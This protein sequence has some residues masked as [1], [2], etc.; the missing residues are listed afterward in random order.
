MLQLMEGNRTEGM[1]KQNRIQ[2][3]K[4]A[5]KK[6]RVLIGLDT[7][8]TLFTFPSG[9]VFVIGCNGIRQTDVSD[10]EQGEGYVI[11]SRR[12]IESVQARLQ[13][14]KADV[15]V[16]EAAARWGLL[17]DIVN[18]WQSRKPHD[19][20]AHK[21]VPHTAGMGNRT[22]TYNKKHKNNCASNLLVC[23]EADGL[24]SRFAPN[25]TFK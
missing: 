1:S 18:N 5:P 11:L 24:Q 22:G 3:G 6:H 16:Y 8:K 15:R 17:Y 9:V 13:Q 20:T 21:N 19:C 12:L 10:D 23:K 7:V 25:A 4:I 2:I 14:H